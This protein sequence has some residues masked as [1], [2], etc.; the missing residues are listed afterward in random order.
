MPKLDTIRAHNMIYR[1]LHVEMAAFVNSH[2]F[3]PCDAMLA[4]YTCTCK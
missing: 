3:L 1:M 4:R 2:S